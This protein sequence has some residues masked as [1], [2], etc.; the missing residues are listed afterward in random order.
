MKALLT[1]PDVC[2]L[3]FKANCVLSSSFRPISLFTQSLKQFKNKV[4][5]AK[6]KRKTILI[7]DLFMFKTYNSVFHYLGQK[8][9]STAVAVNKNV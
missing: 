6:K 3:Q 8:L 1:R 9:F 5:K 7:A 4:I 2:W